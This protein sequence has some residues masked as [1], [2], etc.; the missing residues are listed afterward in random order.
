MDISFSS[1]DLFND[2]YMRYQLLWDCDK[3]VKECHRA[4]GPQQEDIK[5]ET[6]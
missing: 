6:G 3:T 4:S 1:P 5:S 2:Q